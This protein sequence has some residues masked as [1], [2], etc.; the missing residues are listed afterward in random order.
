MLLNNQLVTEEV[1]GNKN[2][3][4]QMKTGNTT[5]QHKSKEKHN[6]PNSMGHNKSISNR[7]VYSDT[8]LSQEIKP[9]T[10]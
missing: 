2:A 7:K 1:R 10:T 9:Q 5:I 6:D 8:S 4:T 3:W